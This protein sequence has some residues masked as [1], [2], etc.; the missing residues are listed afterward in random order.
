[1]LVRRVRSAVGAVC[2]YSAELVETA[3]CKNSTWTE[4]QPR[5]QRV[6]DL[7]RANPNL[8]VSAMAALTVS[9]VR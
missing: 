5:M 9:A 2:D 8:A 1:M 6:L 3:R 4:V 7:A